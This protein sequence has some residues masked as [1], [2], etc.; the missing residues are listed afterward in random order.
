[1]ANI[2]ATDINDKLIKKI[3]SE[4]SDYFD[5]ADDALVS[6]ASRLGLTESQIL[7][8]VTF[9]VKEWLKAYVGKEVCFN[10]LSLNNR[11]LSQEDVTIDV[12]ETKYKWYEMKFAEIDG[13]ITKEVLTGD[14]DTPQEYAY[15]TGRIYRA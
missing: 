1:M 10:N 9:L 8:P 11:L 12:Y 5:R 6:K 13:Q 4:D 2:S 14:A 15:S 7:V 3:V